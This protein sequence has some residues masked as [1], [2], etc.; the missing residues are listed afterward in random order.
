VVPANCGSQRYSWRCQSP[1]ARTIRAV[2]AEDF[3]IV[4][5]SQNG[6]RGAMLDD[7][8]EQAIRSIPEIRS[9]LPLLSKP[10]EAFPQGQDHGLGFVLTSQ[11]RYVFGKEVD[12]WI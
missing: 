7:L 8:N 5:R 4:A 11:S 6:E 1:S 2:I 10:F 3:I 9:W 12:L